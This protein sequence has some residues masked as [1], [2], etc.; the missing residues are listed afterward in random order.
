MQALFQYTFPEKVETEYKAMAEQCHSIRDFQLSIIYHTIQKIIKTTAESF[1]VSGFDRLEPGVSYLFI[2]N[3]RDIILDTSLLNVALHDHN[4]VMTA[5]AIGDNLVRK[6]SLLTL[7]RLN[8]NFLIRRGLSPREMLESSREVSAYIK[9]LLEEEKRSVWIAQREGRTKDGNDATHQGVLKMLGLSKGDQSLM[10]HFKSLRIVPVSISYEFDPTDVLKMPELLAR[11]YEQEY[12]KSANEDFNTILKGA[13]GFKKRIH[14]AAGEIA[15]ETFDRIEASFET[16]NQQL[17]ALASA[18]DTEIHRNY[19]LWPS[20]YI[21]YDLLHGTQEYAS[22]YHEKEKRQFERRI[23][24][25]IDPSDPVALENF[26]NMYAHPVR[27]QKN[28]ITETL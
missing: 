15:P 7:S 2:S 20:N 9:S 13:T 8:R 4:L 18:L 6:P 22:N 23:E 3:H 26:L 5:S 24:R 1:T 28:A 10:Q 12:V 11:H 16:A 21:A 14:L 19:H 17:Q 27:N 25:R